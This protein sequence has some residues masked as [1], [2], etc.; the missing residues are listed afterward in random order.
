[1]KYVLFLLYIFLTK[2]LHFN[3]LCINTILKMISKLTH[4]MKLFFCMYFIE[5]N[6]IYYYYYVNI[7]YYMLIF[8]RY[9]YYKA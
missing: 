4:E 2:I 3:I 5:M 1:M 9:L 6:I 7:I 8:S